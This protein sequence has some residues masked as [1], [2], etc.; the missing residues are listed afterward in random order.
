MK[1]FAS[2]LQEPPVMVMEGMERRVL[3]YGGS[4]MIAV[5]TF[6]ANVKAARHSHPH[7]Q[8]GYLVSGELDF[9]IEGQEPKRLRAGDTYYVGPNVFH[10]V[11]TYSKSVLLDCFTPI[12]E[13]FLGKE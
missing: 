6:E 10:Y 11:I 7:E 12:R 1:T 5:F 4:L 13:D 2:I 9:F 8:A 3:S